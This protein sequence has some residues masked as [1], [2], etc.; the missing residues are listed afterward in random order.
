MP[1]EL[2]PYIPL[3]MSHGSLSASPEI[4]LPQG[5][6]LRLFRPGDE[7]HWAAIT[8]D[9]G[10]FAERSGALAYF[11]DHFGGHLD[12]LGERCL[13][14]LDGSGNPVGT[15]TGWMMDDAPE[16]GR[17]HWVAIMGTYQGRRLSKP[18]VAAAMKVMLQHGH[19]KAMLTTQP[20]SWKGIKTY[21]DLGWKPYDDGT[22]GY[23]KGWALV[24]DLSGRKELSAF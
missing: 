3:M 5:Y 22:S 15:A 23:K 6:S 4:S 14:L 9:A 11:T 24:K 7:E 1:N 2:I 21:L 20:K 19:E 13:F 8:M 17:L 10:E 12:L 16:V 18:L